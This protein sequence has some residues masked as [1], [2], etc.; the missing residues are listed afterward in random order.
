M[1]TLVLLPGMDGT[2]AL[3]APLVEALRSSISVQVVRYP[4]HEVLDYTALTAIAR[5]ALPTD[6]P[7]ILLGESFSGPIAVSLATA[8]PPQLRGVILCCT[9]VRSPRPWLARFKAL[10]NV[11]PV[12]WVP[13]CLLNHFLL[14]RDSTAALRTALARALASIPPVVRRARLRAVSSVDVV[15]ELQRIN[16]PILYLRATRDRVVPRAASQ[17]IAQ[18]RSLTKVVAVE[19]PHLLLQT[20]PTEAARVIDGFMREQHMAGD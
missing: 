7:Y 4:T 10:L 1:M 2:G 3:F 17:L 5:A 18:W 16:V 13:A 8:A 20:A 9:F 11:V 12:T 15:V 19:G 14:G 6:A